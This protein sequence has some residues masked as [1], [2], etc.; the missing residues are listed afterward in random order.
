MQLKK[1]KQGKR[2][3]GLNHI[4]Y[5]L[6]LLITLRLSPVYCNSNSHMFKQEQF[7][8]VEQYFFHII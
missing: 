8:P 5:A 7:K 1:A 3:G 6:N 2:K 4:L